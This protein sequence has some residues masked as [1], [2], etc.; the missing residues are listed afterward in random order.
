MNEYAEYVHCQ[1]V[2]HGQIEKPEHYHIAE[3]RAI[4]YLFKDIPKE[5]RVLD[6]GCGSGKG[7]KYLQELGYALV[8]GIELHPEKAK[9]AGASHGDI[10]SFN[11]FPLTYDV[12]YCSHAFEHMFNP[13]LALDRMMNIAWEFI[14]ILPYVDTGDKK[15]HCAS[16]ELGTLIDDG[17][18]TVNKWF[19]GRG[20]TL[21]E[22]KLDSFR[23]P[24][25][26]LRYKR[27]AVSTEGTH[28]PAV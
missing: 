17:G 1:T 2:T 7:M 23:E 28:S 22:K 27:Y 11:F 3:R 26:W 12:V 20:L 8:D 14:F 21:I 15:A 16:P 5:L 24:E 6:V 9:I 25:I 10:A 18:E 13:N 4:D 19:V